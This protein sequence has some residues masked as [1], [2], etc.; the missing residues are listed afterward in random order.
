MNRWARDLLANGRVEEGSCEH[1]RIHSLRL[2]RGKWTCFLGRSSLASVRARD[3]LEKVVELT[4]EGLES[5]HRSN[6]SPMAEK[7]RFAGRGL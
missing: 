2:V 6:A 5:A 1:R 3:P 4:R 7:T